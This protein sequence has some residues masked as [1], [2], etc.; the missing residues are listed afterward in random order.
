MT[1]NELQSWTENGL[2]ER[3]L[4]KTWEAI[5]P[6]LGDD[7]PIPREDVIELVLDADRVLTYGRDREAAKALYSMNDEERESFLRRAFND[8]SY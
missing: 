1:N 8:S 4:W 3:A 7:G 6:D 5:V 2:I